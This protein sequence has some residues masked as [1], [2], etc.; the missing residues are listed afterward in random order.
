M[1]IARKEKLRHE[2]KKNHL[3][4]LFGPQQVR[5]QHNGNVAR[6]H[7]I[8]ITGLGKLRKELD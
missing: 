7:F 3:P 4:F 2:V 6:S 1:L 8:N 5:A